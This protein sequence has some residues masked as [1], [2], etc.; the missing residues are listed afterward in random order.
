MDGFGG[1]STTNGDSPEDDYYWY[2]DVF[3]E[4]LNISE[5]DYIEFKRLENLFL[6]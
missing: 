6:P 3:D 5:V 4:V 2:Y 1:A